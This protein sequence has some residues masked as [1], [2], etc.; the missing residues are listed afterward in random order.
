M[1]RVGAVSGEGV[2][3]AVLALRVL[4]HLGRERREVGVT[5][6]ARALG[7]TKSRIYRHLRTLVEHGFIVQP[8][9]S[10]RY[11]VG[12]RL[13]ALARSVSDNIDL[14]SAATDALIE[15][16]D[17]LGHSSV[18]SQVEADGVRVL[19]TVSGKAPIEIGVRPGSVLPFHASAQG[20]I[21]LAFNSPEFRARALRAKLDMLTSKTIVSPTALRAELDKVRA[22]GWATAANQS[23]IGLNT[24]AAP[25]FDAS[26]AICGTVGI[27]DM[28]QFIE[29]EPSEDQIAH[30]V[31]AG[32]KI[33]LALGYAP[34][35]AGGEA[36][37]KSA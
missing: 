23:A 27:V 29:E 36:A 6:L 3:A 21:A 16:R 2:Q 24:L 19:A 22:Q 12:P 14:A 25:I 28:V 15:L 34:R 4:E 20:K 17:A 11:K 26:G 37:V 7:T 8:L 35:Q 9:G 10:D 32:R 5:A 30:T 31:A 33:S 18:V 1:P 13:V